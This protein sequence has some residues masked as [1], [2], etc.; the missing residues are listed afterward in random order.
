MVR[1]KSLITAV[2]AG[3]I[4]A[5]SASANKITD[6]AQLKWLEKYANPS[7]HPEA[8]RDPVEH[9]SRTLTRR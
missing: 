1:L 7:R 6:E 8:G 5:C 9:L 2:F 3:V 4:V